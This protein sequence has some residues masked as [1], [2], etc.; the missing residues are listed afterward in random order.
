MTIEVRP[1][2]AWDDEEFDAAYDVLVAAESFGRPH[3]TPDDREAVRASLVHPSATTPV[4][5]WLA[6]LAGQPAGVVLA[7]WPLVDDRQMC[8]PTLGVAPGVRRRG[9]GSALYEVLRRA[10]RMAGRSIIQVEVSHPDGVD[11]WPGVAF[12]EH[13]GFELALR[14]VHAVLRLPVAS[15]RLSLRPGDGYRVDTW[16]DHCPDE[17]VDAYC[18]LREIFG[19]EAPTGTLIMDE[20]RWSIER[21]RDNEQRRMVQGISSWTSL[22]RDRDGTPAGFTELVASLTARDAH[23]H[24]TLVI[25]EHR[26]HRLGAALKAANLRQLV[27]DLPGVERVHTC[28]EPSNVAMNAVNQELGY[29]AA[30]LLEEWQIDLSRRS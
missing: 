23:Q 12:A 16:R 24:Q 30:E 8:W 26:G 4:Q 17:L 9:V 5:G 14:E 20:Q 21:L 2:D 10:V 13:H 19:R 11:R 18:R 22:A 6:R 7:A 29:Q 28:V 15:E 1:L 3:A 25:P 27:I